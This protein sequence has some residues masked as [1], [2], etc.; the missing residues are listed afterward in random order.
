MLAVIASLKV[1]TTAFVTTQGGPSYVTWFF[2]LHI[3]NQAFKYFPLG[4][5]Q[6]F[7]L[8]VGGHSDRLYFLPNLVL[9]PL[10]ALRGWITIMAQQTLSQQAHDQY[11]LDQ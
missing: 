2:A 1:F 3:Y 11:G 7:G 6:R 8:G 4:L 9:A 5:R 10:G